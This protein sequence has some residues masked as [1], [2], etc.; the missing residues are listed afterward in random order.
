MRALVIACLLA[1]VAC[2]PD[3]VVDPSPDGGDVDAGE[4][5][6]AETPPDADATSIYGTWYVTF[7]RTDCAGGETTQYS[8]RFIV[9]E[10]AQVEIV[11]PP[12]PVDPAWIMMADRKHGQVTWFEASGAA[13]YTVTINNEGTPT[14]AVAYGRQLANGWCETS[15][16]AAV[17]DYAP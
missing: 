13:E 4:D 17:V 5:A 9:R 2:D 11:W 3:D 10:L 6:D 16:D 14:A 15:D 1:L 12:R 8:V 7:D